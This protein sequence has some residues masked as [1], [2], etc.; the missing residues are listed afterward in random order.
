MKI[1]IRPIA[2]TDNPRIAQVIR[3]I[4]KEHGVDKPGTVYTDPTTDTLFEVFQEERSAY[5][6]VEIDGVIQGGCGIYPTNGLPDGCVELVKLY[7]H[8]SARGTGLG[9]Q[10]MEKSIEYAA[11][12]GYTS[13]YL[14]TFPEL[15]SAVDLYRK[16]G[17]ED[18]DSALGNSGHFACNMWMLKQLNS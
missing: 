4:L 1:N 12:I 5:W 17:F 13:V 3:E 8:S 6:V 18:L 2:P 15:G 10:L 7:L 11:S 16:L 14:E 9:R